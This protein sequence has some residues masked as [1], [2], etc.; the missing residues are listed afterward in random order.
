[1]VPVAVP[2]ADLTP[3]ADEAEVS[4][5]GTEDALIA[6]AKEACHE[7]T[8]FANRMQTSGVSSL[9]CDADVELRR[10]RAVAPDG[11]VR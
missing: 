3:A 10:K 1:V 8:C 4:R 7:F 2:G 6:I 5:A 11:G 9:P